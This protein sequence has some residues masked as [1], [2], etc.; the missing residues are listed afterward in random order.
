MGEFVAVIA[1]KI[2]SF[3]RRAIVMEK[4]D[5]YVFL[6]WRLLDGTIRHEPPP[7][8]VD[9]LV[10][11]VVSALVLQPKVDAYSLF[12]SK[13]KSSD[14]PERMDKINITTKEAA[15]RANMGINKIREL[16]KLPD[17]PAFLSGKRKILINAEQ[18]DKWLED[19]S[20]RRSG[21][22]RR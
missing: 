16:C 2:K 17:F 11:A 19:K 1:E 15:I 6:G 9:R 22:K 4:E 8:V 10:T 21:F 14:S 3:E 20:N 13:E 5:Q 12:D 7:E 18:F